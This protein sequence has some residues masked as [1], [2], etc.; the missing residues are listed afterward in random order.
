MRNLGSY[1]LGYEVAAK[2]L[3]LMEGLPGE[4]V[5]TNMLV[6]D[7]EE[8]RAMSGIYDALRDCQIDIDYSAV[9]KAIEPKKFHGYVQTR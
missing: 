8:D 9:L 3:K 7:E 6:S 4:F 5:A 2:R 1:G